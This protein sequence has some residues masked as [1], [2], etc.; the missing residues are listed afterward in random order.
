MPQILLPNKMLYLSTVR[1]SQ[2][3]TDCCSYNYVTKANEF[4]TKGGYSD[5]KHYQ[6]YI[7]LCYIATIGIMTCMY[8][9]QATYSYTTI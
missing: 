8:V 6:E 5:C 2:F 7:M 4:G 9:T 3:V 1:A